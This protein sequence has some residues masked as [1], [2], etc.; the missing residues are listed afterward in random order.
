MR[1]SI[2]EVFPLPA[3]PFT[4]ST[5]TSSWRTTRFCSFWMVAVM[6]CICAERRWARDASSSASWMATV[7]SKYASN[8]SSSML[9]WRRSSRSAWMMR[10]LAS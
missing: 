2:T 3:T 8:R 10:P 9:N 1:C 5:G 4:S 6:A 7:V